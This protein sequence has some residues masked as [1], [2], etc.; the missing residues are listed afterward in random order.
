MSY[1]NTYKG[2]YKI[3]KPEKYVGDPNNVT[4]R[5][6]WERAC[7]T[8]CERNPKVVRW[9]SEEIIIPYYDAGR[10]R[11]RRY[12]MDLMIEFSDGKKIIVEVKPKKQTK[13]PTKRGKKKARYLEESMTF[14]TNQCKWQAAEKYA[15]DRGW[16]FHIWHEDI[17]KSLGILKG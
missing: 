11:Q 10:K 4:Y 3:K 1:G 14:V 7:F 15:K 2:K 12:F 5:S 13:P 17:L 16:Q 6:L 9:S 8:W